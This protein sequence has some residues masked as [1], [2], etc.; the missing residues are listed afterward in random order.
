M[1]VIFLVYGAGG[2]QLKRNPLGRSH[3]RHLYVEDPTTMTTVLLILAFVVVWLLVNYG[4]ATESSWRLLA[5]RYRAASEP[6]GT[7]LHGQVYR[8]GNVSEGWG[9]TVLSVSAAGLY[10]RRSGLFRPFHHPLLI[11]WQVISHAGA[12]RTWW[13]RDWHALELDAIT[14]LRLSTRAFQ[15]VAP[16]VG[17]PANAAA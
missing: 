6:S 12:G 10:L 17:P 4:F 16:Y 3:A 15:I 13:G 1:E 9:I 14:V 8:M 5:E 7:S 2:P 11:P